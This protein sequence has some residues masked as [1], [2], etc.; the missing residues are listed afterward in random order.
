MKRE[1]AIRMLDK[2]RNDLPSP[3][4][5]ESKDS[6]ISRCMADSKMLSEYPD[7]KQ[8]A[9]VCYSQSGEK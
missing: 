4:G 7:E 3:S 9:A 6:F 2:I 5:K 1:N 8:R